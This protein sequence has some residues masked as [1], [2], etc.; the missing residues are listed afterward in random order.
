[1]SFPEISSRGGL[2][3]TNSTSINNIRFGRCMGQDDVANLDSMVEAVVEAI[4]QQ[5]EENK[6]KKKE[7]QEAFRK[8][9]ERNKK[10][11]YRKSIKNK[12]TF[13]FVKREG[14]VPMSQLDGNENINVETSTSTSTTTLPVPVVGERVK[15]VH[16]TPEEIKKHRALTECTMYAKKKAT[17]Q[18]KAKKPKNKKHKK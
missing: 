17:K 4:T 5:R 18:P 15:P 3:T 2:A 8:E 13:L 16:K 12:R 9:R 10:Q 7:E 1:M 11:K 6:R 14:C